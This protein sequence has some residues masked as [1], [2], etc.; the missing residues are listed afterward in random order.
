MTLILEGLLLPLPRWTV[1]LKVV[2]VPFCEGLS[3]SLSGKVTDGSQYGLISV[4]NWISSSLQYFFDAALLP[5][6]IMICLAGA[7]EN[8]SLIVFLF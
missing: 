8:F 4:R 5:F 2:G 1:G 6:S 7:L 3:I